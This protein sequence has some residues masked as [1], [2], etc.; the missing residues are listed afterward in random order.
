[1]GFP[2]RK[3]SSLHSTYIGNRVAV[4][5]DSRSGSVVSVECRGRFSSMVHA[6]FSAIVLATASV[7]SAGWLSTFWQVLSAGGRHP[8]QFLLALTQQQFLQRP[9][10]L[11]QQHK[12][13]SPGLAR[14]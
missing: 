10:L 3:L 1:M 7:L 14:L 11:H 12:D 13:T 5:G 6:E 2:H 8:V 4:F 9:C